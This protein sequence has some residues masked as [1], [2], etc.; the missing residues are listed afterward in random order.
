MRSFDSLPLAAVLDTQFLCVHGGLSPDITTLADIASIDRFME[1]PTTGA[2]S[3]MLWADPLPDFVGLG[4]L[5]RVACVR[6][7]C[8]TAAENSF[9]LFR[10]VPDCIS[11]GR[12]HQWIPPPM[13]SS[14]RAACLLACVLVVDV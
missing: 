4:G 11:I 12:A 9:V 10:T 3:D 1:P 2:M 6:A 5:R 8:S 7:R 13:R 14:V